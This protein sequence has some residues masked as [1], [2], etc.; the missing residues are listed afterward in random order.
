M[1]VAC[2]FLIMKLYEI[3]RQVNW[4]RIYNHKWA[5]VLVISG[6]TLMILC[7][8]L[9]YKVLVKII[10][11]A[12]IPFYEIRSLYCKTNLYKYLPGNVFQYVGRNQLAVEKNLGHTQIAL[13]TML[14]ILLTVAVSVL[15]AVIFS[16]DALAHWFGS[17][18]SLYLYVA[19]G[20]VLIAVMLLIAVLFR[21]KFGKIWKRMGTLFSFQGAVGMLFA[22][23]WLFLMMVMNG[24]LFGSVMNMTGNA[25]SRKER[26]TV[27][28]LFALSFCIGYL[29]PG[30]PGGVGVRETML[31]V[32]LGKTVDEAQTVA[33]VV[34]YRVI[35][36]LGDVFAYWLAAAM[37]HFIT[38]REDK[39]WRN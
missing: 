15:T 38:K 19:A 20:L 8:P 25:L 18:E 22:I 13:A 30:A 23:T 26:H 10:T 5:V 1:A 29:T 32:F 35:S 2:L 4:D 3:G 34:I 9:S 39:R 6:Y 31:L 28:G 36:V 16:K 17:N 7:S 21:D 12:E 27:I 37:G 24:V 11:G 14:E 33:A